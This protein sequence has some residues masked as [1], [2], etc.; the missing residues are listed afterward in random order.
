MIG[1]VLDAGDTAVNK[2]S[3][4]FCWVILKVY[5]NY[6]L[7]VNKNAALVS[8]ENETNIANMH[9]SPSKSKYEEA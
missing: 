2:T 4:H 8:K 6:T 1:S 9:F 3:K 5:H 7:A